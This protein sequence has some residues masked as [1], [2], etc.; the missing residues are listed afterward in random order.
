MIKPRKPAIVIKPTQNH[1][2]WRNASTYDYTRAFT[3][4]AWAWEFLRRNRAYAVAAANA[5]RSVSRILRRW[6]MIIIFDAAETGTGDAHS[7][8]LHSFRSAGLSRACRRR[9]LAGR[10]VSRRSSRRRISNAS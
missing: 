7:W 2:D 5:P 6:P 4:E 9:I 10:R 1:P 3:R 8:G